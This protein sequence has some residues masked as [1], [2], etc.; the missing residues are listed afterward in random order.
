MDSFKFALRKTEYDAVYIT[1]PT[2]AKK[3]VEV[4]S[5]LYPEDGPEILGVDI[6]TAP[7]RQYE[8]HAMGG[9]SPYLSQVCMLQIYAPA[10]S[11]VFIFRVKDLGLDI[12]KEFLETRRFVAHFAQ[13][14]MQHFLHAGIVPK[15]LG[16]SQMLFRLL[17]HA[18][19][20]HTEAVK[21]NLVGLAKVS[22]GVDL[23]KEEQT[24]DWS[25]EPT[26]AQKIYAAR[27]AVL[28]Q[29]GATWCAKKIH[30]MGIQEL[31]GVYKLNREAQIAIAQMSLNG[32][33]IDKKYHNK[34]IRG[35][36]KELDSSEE[37]LRKILPKTVN[38]SSPKQMS[39]WL[40]ERLSETKSGK[41]DLD[42][43]P[44]SPKTGL[45][46]CD[47]ETFHL[48]DHYPF[49]KPLLR[50]K[51]M[52]KLVSTYGSTLQNLI[53][54]K[55]GRIHASFSQCFTGTGR[56]SSF[57]PNLQNFPRAKEMRSIFTAGKDRLYVCADYGQMEVRVAAHISGDRRML[58]AF[59]EGRDIYTQTASLVLNTD[60][61]KLP[62]EQFKEYRQMYKGI[63]LGSLFGLG[64]QT[65]KQYMKNEPY[66]IDMDIV[67]CQNAID[68]FRNAY[69]EFRDWQVQTTSEAEITLLSHT[70]SGKV[71]KLPEDSYYCKSLNTPV[72]GTAAEIMLHAAI[73]V[74]TWIR[75]NKSKAMLVNLVHDEV[76]VECPTNELDAVMGMVKSSMEKAML[77]IFPD[78]TMNGL[79][80]VDFGKN[81]GEAK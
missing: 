67:E 28:T 69:P 39:A 59:E 61:S 37:E 12:L 4:L 25:S 33:L 16:C 23:S 20:A 58:Q 50:Y 22:A 65:M 71:R 49:V 11:C 43:W 18:K 3:A 68:D 31:A 42:E 44:R 54:P 15:N 2:D 1:T 55:T 32:I 76:L 51:K 62:K 52:A 80:G 8:N 9:L 17:V 34:L 60:I 63:L 10:H 38:M 36:Q 41:S 64:A 74:D 75:E 66:N 24:S 70:K 14:E 79:V 27:D 78:A 30:E 73:G 7:L 48:H 40:T 46:K 5:K 29:V 81:W 26:E 13:F 57:K 77:A 19:T 72:Q 47:A 56:M 53:N 6:E 45:L 35:W 21:T